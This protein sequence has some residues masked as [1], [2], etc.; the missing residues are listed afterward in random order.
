MADIIIDSD[1]GKFKAG[2]DLDLEI[3]NNG[4]HSYI[5]NATATQSIVLRTRAS[6]GSTADAVTIGADKNV[7]MVGNL[8]IDA[9][10]KG[11]ILGA[12]QD[13]T[14]YSG[15][16][17]E[18]TFVMGS[19]TGVGTNEGYIGMNIGDGT[20]TTLD[21]RGGE[22][23]SAYLRLTA[24]QGDDNAD[25]YRM[26]VA[27]G[28]GLTV[29][30]YSTGSWV[31]GLAVNASSQVGIN[32]TSPAS[33]LTIKDSTGNSNGI[34][35][36]LVLLADDGGQHTSSDI[37]G[38]ITFAGRNDGGTNKISAQITSP[39][40]SNWNDT[41]ANGYGQIAFSVGQGSAVNEKMR[42]TNNGVGI[43]TTS[44][45]GFEVASIHIS[46]TGQ[47]SMKCYGV[48]VPGDSNTEY[49]DFAHDSSTG[50]ARINTRASG[51][52]TVR[53]LLFLTNGTE[54]MR[55]TSGGD[56]YIGT[57][58][59]GLSINGNTGG[60][61]T[62]TGI[63]QALSA[64]KKL[65]LNATDFSFKISG[66][67]K[68]R[69]MSAGELVIP[70]QPAFMAYPSGP[71]SD[72]ANDSNVEIAFGTERFDQGSNFASNTFTAPATGKYQLNV[73]LE[74]TNMDSAATYYQVNLATSN[75]IYYFYIDPDFGQDTAG[76]FTV[77]GSVLADMDTND[78]AV[79][80]VRTSDGTAQMDVA[81]QS[82]FSGF[83]AC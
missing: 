46:V 48:G 51:S 56:V 11:L 37:A 20:Y 58:N 74:F 54:R 24:D 31:T 26:A 59:E 45:D 23:G 44:P 50:N 41:V 6:G 40:S 80:Q 35:K 62:I 15:D 72:I 14:I 49:L 67:E 63:N 28:G 38:V 55:I 16:S 60:A 82:F 32:T 13:A 57:A 22:D 81:T 34:A 27:A 66:T 30:S 29:D 2:D 83:L 71:Q 5:A 78:T 42:V 69:L 18:I 36:G 17:G 9:N 75:D 3:Y 10:D 61:G 47:Y 8:I 68:M 79:V 7:T 21:V 43:G 33:L 39:S 77:G 53:P 64:Y 70:S 12:D 25:H 1:S 52:G 4:S 19:G 76:S 73:S 65:V